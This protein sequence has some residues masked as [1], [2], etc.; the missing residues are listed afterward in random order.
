MHAGL[1]PDDSDDLPILCTLALHQDE[2]LIAG[3]IWAF[4]PHRCHV[5]TERPLT[6]GMVVSLVLH[7]S[8]SARVRLGLGIV[9]WARAQECGIAFPHSSAS[10][11]FTRLSSAVGMTA[12]A[13]RSPVRPAEQC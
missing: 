10:T 7:L 13:E 2:T 1:I 9:T 6:P 3:T 11:T 8:T 4:Y 12:V 5:E